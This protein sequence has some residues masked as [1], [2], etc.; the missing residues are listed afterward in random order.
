[1]NPLEP[2]F[3]ITVTSP[4]AARRRRISRSLRLGALGLLLAVAYLA[5][6]PIAAFWQGDESATTPN[7]DPSLPTVADA[8]SMQRQDGRAC[9]ASPSPV[10]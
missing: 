7:Y 2:I 1:M 6:S 10:G 8:I 5:P 9:P 3:T 4:A